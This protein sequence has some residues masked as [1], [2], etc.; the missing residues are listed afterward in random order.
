MDDRSGAFDTSNADSGLP[1]GG[2][3]DAEAYQQVA[4][5]LHAP[6]SL[7]H[8]SVRGLARTRPEFVQVILE[9]SLHFG[10]PNGQSNGEAVS[11]AANLNDTIDSLTLAAER[12]RKTDCFRGVDVYVDEG[13]CAED[14]NGTVSSTGITCCDATFTVHEVR[15]YRLQVGTSV[16]SATG[17]SALE[18]GG[19]FLNVFGAGES[20]QGT[21]GLGFGG[22]AGDWT[23]GLGGLAALF[24]SGHRV[25]GDVRA[26]NQLQVEVRKPYPLGV[27]D[28]FASLRLTN[29]LLN[30]MSTSSYCEFQRGLETALEGTLGRIGYEC[31]WRDLGKV[32]AHASMPVREQAGHSVKSA[33]HYAWEQ[34]VRD[35]SV[36]PADG[37]YCRVFAEVS[38]LGGDPLTRYVKGECEYQWH[39]QLAA[40]RVVPPTMAGTAGDVDDEDAAAPSWAAALSPVLSLGARM[41][42]MAP[43]WRSPAERGTRISDRFFVGGPANCFRGFRNHGLGPT[44][45]DD[46]IGGD[47]YYKGTAM[48]SVPLAVNELARSLGLRAHAFVTAGDCRGLHEPFNAWTVGWRSAAGVGLALSTVFGRL[49]INWNKVFRSAAGDQVDDGFT[50]AL[51]KT[52]G[53]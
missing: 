14:G 18:I 45:G 21:A 49:E 30:R 4:E 42:A 43:V 1:D 22:R 12:L 2:A 31:T 23:T 3:A 41:G 20:V 28:T 5:L 7:Q 36:I 10:L 19:S 32:G 37:S 15:P 38:G 52:F 48:L 44:A 26:S 33:V 24:G 13:V 40:V 8:V 17:E 46:A 39:T 50:L 53:A 34:D 35:D 6:L 51:S 29:A 27:M 25:Y 9:K 11:T 16:E 47:A